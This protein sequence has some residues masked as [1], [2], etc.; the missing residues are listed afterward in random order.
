MAASPPRKKRRPAAKSDRD[1][2]PGEAKGVIA[3]AVMA[4]LRPGHPR[5]RFWLSQ[6]R[7]CPAQWHVLGPAKPDPSAGHDEL[8]D[9]ASELKRQSDVILR[10]RRGRRLRTHQIIQFRQLYARAE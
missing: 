8:E 3:K 9:H 7:G 6:R 10:Q 4:G 2:G 5:L 1:G